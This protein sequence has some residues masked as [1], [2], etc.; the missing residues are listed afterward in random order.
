MAAALK[1][2]PSLTLDE[3]QF[4]LSEVSWSNNP[5]QHTLMRKLEVFTLK[6]THGITS[7]SHV[8]IGRAS[9]ESQL[10][11]APDDRIE[12]LLATYKSNPR[13]LSPAQLKQVQF[14]RFQND[15]MTSEEE[16]S[17]LGSPTSN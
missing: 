15:M 5:E 13:A 11:L 9:L 7:P 12:T 16:E 3:I 6:A 8:T 10:G 14:H 17:Y 2:R 1:F 4:L